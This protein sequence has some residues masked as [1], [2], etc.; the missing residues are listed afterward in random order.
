MAVRMT[1]E[2]EDVHVNH[3]VHEISHTQLVQALAW[4]L[5]HDE[6]N[7]AHIEAI[8]DRLE[9]IRAE[10]DVAVRRADA[11]LDRVS[12]PPEVP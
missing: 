5:D 10:C 9:Q 1:D 4:K 11:W 6:P 8:V 3:C 12:N 7:R 2:P